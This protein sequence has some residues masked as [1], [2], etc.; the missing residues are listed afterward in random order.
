[1]KVFLS[2][3]SVD[4]PFVREFDNTL[5]AFGIETFLDE[6]DIALGQDIVQRIYNEI[7]RADYLA[8]FISNNSINSEWVNEELSVAKMQEKKQKGIFILPILIDKLTKIPTSI[9]SK[10]FADFSNRTIDVKADNFKLVLKAFQVGEIEDINRNIKII[11]DQ[12]KQKVIS[13][14]LIIASEFQY[15]LSD[16]SFVLRF[17]TETDDETISYR[18]YLESKTEIIYRDFN[19]K[20]EILM[21]NLSKIQKVSFVKQLS[22][23]VI[24]RIKKFLFFHYEYVNLDSSFKPENNWIIEFAE[25][26]R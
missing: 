13:E 16:T 24:K 8:Y 4:K 3:S 5:R 2:H 20:T 15:L 25:S 7:E 11:E 22:D 26:A 23:D 10:R 6:K 18:R 1:M 14:F 9:S 17:I 12:K 21:V 19:S